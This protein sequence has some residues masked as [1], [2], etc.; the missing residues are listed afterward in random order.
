MSV[1]IDVIVGASAGGGGD[2]TVVVDVEVESVVLLEVESVTI[3]SAKVAEQ[4]ATIMIP[5]INF[6]IFVFLLWF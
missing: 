4:A 1:L 6:F 3:G 5:T 2:L